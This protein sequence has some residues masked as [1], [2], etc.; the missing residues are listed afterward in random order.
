MRLA[1]DESGDWTNAFASKP[2]PTV[3]T[4]TP[5]LTADAVSG[6]GFSRESVRRRAAPLITGESFT[7]TLTTV[8]TSHR[9][10]NHG[11]NL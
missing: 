8:E 4:H 9:N 11:R 10:I 3:T 5:G 1:S 2:A 7:A 6:T